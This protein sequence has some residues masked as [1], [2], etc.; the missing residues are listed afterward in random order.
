M[1]LLKYV[2]DNHFCKE[3]YMSSDIHILI[4]LMSCYCHSMQEIEFFI[5]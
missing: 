5:V 4:V 3:S 1:I 2:E